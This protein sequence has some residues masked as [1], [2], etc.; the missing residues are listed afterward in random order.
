MT[1]PRSFCSTYQKQDY[2][3]LGLFLYQKQ[4]SCVGLFSHDP[5]AFSKSGWKLE[6]NWRTPSTYGRK[7][8]AEEWLSCVIDLC[9][10]LDPRSGACRSWA[11]PTLCFCVF[12]PRSYSTLLPET[13][14][15][16]CCGPLSFCQDPWNSVLFLEKHHLPAVC[17]PLR[18]EGH[19][20][21]RSSEGK[22]SK[23]WDQI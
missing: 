14:I 7:K 18:H 8:G 13:L 1:C 12:S 19:K 3:L 21:G 23:R 11:V 22:R 16:F 20:Y 10:H 6:M 4:D 15:C 5:A 17:Q 9:T 2:N